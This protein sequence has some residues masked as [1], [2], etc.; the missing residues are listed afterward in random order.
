M[1]SHDA[2]YILFCNVF[3]PSPP[4]VHR[5]LAFVLCILYRNTYLDCVVQ[6]TDVCWYIGQSSLPSVKTVSPAKRNTRQIIFQHRWRQTSK[7]SFVY[8]WAC[9]PLTG[10]SGET[11]DALTILGY[12]IGRAELQ[13]HTHTVPHTSQAGA[14]VHTWWTWLK[15]IVA[16]QNILHV[17]TAQVCLHTCRGTVAALPIKY[18][19]VSREPHRC[20]HS[21][22]LKEWAPGHLST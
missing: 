15:N 14:L 7:G 1:L 10:E 3:A 21:H 22:R 20:H 16:K 13:Y 11:G 9:M 12:L 19:Q 8:N 18:G 4:C 5:H 2:R 6:C 17:Y